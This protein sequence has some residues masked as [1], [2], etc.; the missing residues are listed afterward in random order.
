M[1]HRERIISDSESHG[2]YKCLNSVGN[3]Q[4]FDLLQQ[5]A[6]IFTTVIQLRN[7]TTGMKIIWLYRLLKTKVS[8]SQNRPFVVVVDPSIPPT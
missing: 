3:V 7:K 5:V 2:T 4:R 1:Q 6:Q 8:Q